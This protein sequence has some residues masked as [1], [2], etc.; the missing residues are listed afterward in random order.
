MF[1][2]R[3]KRAVVLPKRREADA[4]SDRDAVVVLV[5]ASAKAAGSEFA[6]EEAVLMLVM[7][8]GVAAMSVGGRTVVMKVEM[9]RHPVLTFDAIDSCFRDDGLV[10]STR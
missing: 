5:L 3:S 7:V 2:D 10:E 1:P 9:M 8:N 6:P 4:S